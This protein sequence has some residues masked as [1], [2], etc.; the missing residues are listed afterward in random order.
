MRN[1]EAKAEAM[2]SSFGVLSNRQLAPPV[3]DQSWKLLQNW[4][5]SLITDQEKCVRYARFKA[6]QQIAHA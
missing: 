1:L 5:F 4:L 3:V 2:I 6:C